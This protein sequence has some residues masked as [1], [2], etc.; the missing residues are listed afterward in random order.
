VNAKRLQIQKQMEEQFTE[1][2]QKIKGNKRRAPTHLKLE[3]YNAGQEAEASTFKISTS[4]K[5]KGRS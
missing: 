5:A 3:R 1:A 2:F 4:D